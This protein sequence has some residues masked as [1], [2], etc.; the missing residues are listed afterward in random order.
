MT[1]ALRIIIRCDH[2]TTTGEQGRTYCPAYIISVGGQDVEQA[3]TRAA[4]QNWGFRPGRPHRHIGAHD[5][6]PAHRTD[7]P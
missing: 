1:H 6:C 2:Q 3:R 7:H 5:Y 4:E